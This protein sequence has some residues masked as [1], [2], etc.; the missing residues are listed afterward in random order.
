ML[1]IGSHQFGIGLNYVCN[2]PCVHV[3]VQRSLPIRAVAVTGSGYCAP[4]GQ[5]PSS[6]QI[7][8]S[9]SYS[10][11]AVYWW[12]NTI[13]YGHV[14]ILYHITLSWLLPI[15]N[16]WLISFQAHNDTFNKGRIMNIGFQEAMKYRPWDCVIFHDVDMLPEND[17]NL[18][19]C[20][21]QPRH[22]SPALDEMRYT[23]VV[24]YTSHTVNSAIE[25]A[26]FICFRGFYNYVC[27]CKKT[28]VYPLLE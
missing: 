28:S 18:Y 13:K 1:H 2:R 14:Y 12:R 5:L 7:I 26:P 11:C 8:V 20:S 16:G 17:N 6:S 19:V 3:Y 25:D 22:L 23:W 27:F 15:I 21:G 9:S 24:P 10:I 4:I